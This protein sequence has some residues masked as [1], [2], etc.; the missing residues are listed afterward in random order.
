MVA[1]MYIDLIFY[2]AVFT[3]A[4]SLL[5]AGVLT[6]IFES[7]Y[8]AICAKKDG[9]IRLFREQIKMASEHKEARIQAARVRPGASNLEV[10]VLALLAGPPKLFET[11]LR[12]TEKLKIGVKWDPFKEPFHWEGRKR[13]SRGEIGWIAAIRVLRDQGY[14][15]VPLPT[16][17]GYA[18]IA[19]NQAVA[20]RTAYD[21]LPEAMKAKVRERQRQ[22][23]REAG[24]A[25]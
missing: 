14:I 20:A 9:T 11:F 6:C 12:L 13:A 15:S 10:G 23:Y 2:V 21:R 24:P 3:V 8:R 25:A 17:D 1:D 7:R 16:V 4:L 18:L 22:I 19:S 5:I